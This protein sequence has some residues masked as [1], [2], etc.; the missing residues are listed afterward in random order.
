M[1]SATTKMDTDDMI[2][3][4]ANH[5]NDSS[6][7]GKKNAAEKKSHYENA[8]SNGNNTNTSANM[9]IAATTQ[10]TTTNDTYK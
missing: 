5:R 9:K 2:N 10:A 4:N 1:T 6:I 7:N 3:S 8:N